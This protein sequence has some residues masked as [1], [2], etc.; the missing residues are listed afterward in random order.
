MGNGNRIQPSDIAAL[1][2]LLSKPGGLEAVLAEVEAQKRRAAT[3]SDF[4]R[5]SR[6]MGYPVSQLSGVPGEKVRPRYIRLSLWQRLRAW[7]AGLL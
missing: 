6:V 5:W 3:R 7:W 4:D 1:R 2:D